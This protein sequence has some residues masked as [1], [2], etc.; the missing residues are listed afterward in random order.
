MS[1]GS[2]S[3][4]FP[5]VIILLL[6][7][8]VCFTGCFKKQARQPG[9]H[10]GTDWL[11]PQDALKDTTLVRVWE[12]K[13]PIKADEALERMYI[14]GDYLYALSDRNFMVCMDTQ[15]GRVIFAKNIGEEGFPVVGLNLYRDELFS[16]IAGQLVEINATAGTRNT[17]LHLGYDVSCP[18]G[19]NSSFYYIG[20]VTDR[21][22]HALRADDKIQVF[23]VSAQNDSMITSIIA[24]E[25][26]VIFATDGGNCLSIAP[27]RAKLLWRFDVDGAILGP[28]VRDAGSVYFACED[29]NIYKLNIFTGGF[30]WKYQAGSLLDRGPRLGN[31]LVYQYARSK[32]LTAVD[33]DSGEVIWQLADGLDLVTEADGETYVITKDGDL[34]VMDND[35]AKLLYKVHLSGVSKYA[36]NTTD[37]RLYLAGSD[38]RVACLQ[39]A[40]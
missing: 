13:L 30:V 2:K 37:S 33:K 36:V 26:F 18:A 19:R 1:N 32:G 6:L 21:R 5:V 17:S 24:D 8:V 3:A 22:M 34:A 39:Q 20:A 23:E 7:P 14:F 15:T 11:V 31:R 16:V 40:E 25:R 4:L 27:G 29:T 35:K 12:N 38:G 9:W 28:V 10:P